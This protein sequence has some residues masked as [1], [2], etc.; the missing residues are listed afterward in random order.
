MNRN[1]KIYDMCKEVIILFCALIVATL[2]SCESSSL[3]KQ[4][5]RP[6][7][8]ANANYDISLFSVEKTTGTGKVYEK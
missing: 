2:V 6:Y 8:I 4:P 7:T 5:D 3:W 1:K